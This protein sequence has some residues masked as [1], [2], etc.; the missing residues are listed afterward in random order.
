MVETIKFS[1]IAQNELEESSVWYEEQLIG[2]GE[3]FAKAVHGSA[4]TIAKNP[5]SYPKKKTNVREFVV[6]RFPFIL[7]YEYLK[8][9]N[10]IYILHIFH[11]SR[12]PRHKYKRS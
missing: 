8:K 12:N 7:V 4:R 3:Q 11:T 1:S 5:E 6:E 10:S 2:L 9:E